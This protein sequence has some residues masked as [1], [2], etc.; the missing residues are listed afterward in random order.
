[1]APLPGGRVKEKERKSI[2][3]APFILRTV[4]KRSDMDHA[5]L[6]ANYTMPAFC[7]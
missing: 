3:T 1:V 7:L 6:P 5:V 2:Y 4:S